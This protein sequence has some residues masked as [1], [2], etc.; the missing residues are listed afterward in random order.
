MKLK[1]KEFVSVGL[2]LILMGIMTLSIF[3]V[4]AFL[5][6][7]ENFIY[8]KYE[9]TKADIIDGAKSKFSASVNDLNNNEVV[10]YTVKELIDEGYLKTDEINPLTGKKYNN[11]DKVLVISKNGKI[12]Y[13]IIN[14]STLVKEIKKSN[15]VKIIDNEFYFVGTNPS[16]YIS[17]NEKIY[18]I[19]KMDNKNNIYVVNEETTKKL[20]Y[21]DIEIYLS[22]YVND[23]IIE[24]KDLVNDVLLLDY[25]TYQNTRVYNNSFLEDDNYFWIKYNEE[26]K[27]F[28]SLNSIFL[29]NVEKA[30]IIP[31]IKIDSSAV[32]DKGNGSKINPYVIN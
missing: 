30:W 1:K 20:K 10:E 23:S 24:N 22:S 28:D 26:V 4:P 14:G 11:E 27:V 12:S 29:E 32:V 21:E 13:K 17:F 9:S 3:S 25:Q 5:N 6:I 7:K 16:N 18:R 31:L 2:L 15:D 19:V 8:S